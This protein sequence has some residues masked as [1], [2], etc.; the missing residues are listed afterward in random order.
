TFIP[1]RLYYLE[2]LWRLRMG[3]RI[4]RVDKS[5]GTVVTTAED[6]M[7]DVLNN[8]R[9]GENAKVAELEK[10]IAKMPD[11]EKME[12]YERV[13]NRKSQD[14]L[15]QQLHYRLSHS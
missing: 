10:I 1:V 11:T 2:Q 3:P 9:L 14:P 4:D 8:P 13:K 12:L 6:Q 15:A 5:G 7:K